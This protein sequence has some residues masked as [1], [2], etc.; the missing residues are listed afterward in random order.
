MKRV[1]ALMLM[2]V[3]LMATP[4]LTE[5]YEGR[6]GFGGFLVGCCFGLRTAAAYNEGK[7]LHFRDWGQLIPIVGTVLVI[8]DGVQGYQGIT[9]SDLAAEY[10]SNYY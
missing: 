3:L 5:A 8:W 4:S 6:G 1:S 2:A 7:D 10:G 9:T